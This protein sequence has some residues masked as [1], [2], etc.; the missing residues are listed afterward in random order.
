M[1]FWE[2]F[3]I[4]IEMAESPRMSAAVTVTCERTTPDLAE[5]PDDGRVGASASPQQPTINNATLSDFLTAEYYQ[6]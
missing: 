2:M 5:T 4:V 3:L 1:G 6:S